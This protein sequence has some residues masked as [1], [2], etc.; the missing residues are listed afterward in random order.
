MP[1]FTPSVILF[2]K[3]RETSLLFTNKDYK[4]LPARS[5]RKI[6]TQCH[7]RGN[8]PCLG[9]ER[10]PMK[11]TESLADITTRLLGI[12]RSSPQTA[13]VRRDALLA[14]FLLASPPPKTLQWGQAG[15]QH[16]LHNPP[17]SDVVAKRDDAKSG[18]QTWRRRHGQ[19]SQRPF[20][21]RDIAEAGPHGPDVL[22]L[23]PSK[24][25]DGKHALS[26]IRPPLTSILLASNLRTLD[27]PV[28]GSAM[29]NERRHCK[30]KGG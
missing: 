9:E 24:L 19:A 7:L 6:Q 30:L 22:L 12:A 20:R 8:F 15:G 4:G 14:S 5:R 16:P 10:A 11:S 17:E 27:H 21:L 1:T 3:K 26:S 2:A 28:W 23:I 25:R 13:R 29:R 18:H